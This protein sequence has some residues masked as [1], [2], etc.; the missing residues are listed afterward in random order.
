MSLSIIKY[1]SSGGGGGGTL[2]DANNG[3]SLSGTIAQLGQAVGAVGN[4][5][6]LVDNR[7]IPLGASTL[8]FTGATTQTGIQDSYF[9]HTTLDTAA[10]F[11]LEVAGD[12]PALY[13]QSNTI[14]DGPTIALTNINADALNIGISGGSDSAFI[15]ANTLRLIPGAGGVRSNGS[16]YMG[17]NVSPTAILHIAQGST[18]VAPL[19]L[20]SGSLL[21]T[22]ETAAVE[23]NGTNL[24]F[25]RTGTTRETI[26]TSSA[27]TTESLV[28]NTTITVNINGTNYKLLA[29]TI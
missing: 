10:G 5:A 13:M 9:S 14:T 2:T 18:T 23:Y 24:F 15:Q 19:K 25:T 17:G 6:E 12:F 21:T 28:S 27:V 7:E 11:F 22:P 4:P 16:T 3:L 8:L 20:T 1:P 26:I 29:A